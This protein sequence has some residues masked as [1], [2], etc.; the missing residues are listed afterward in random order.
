MGISAA[1]TRENFLIFDIHGAYGELQE[2]LDKAKFDPSTTRLLVGGDLI[3]RGDDSRSV[4]KLLR[5][6]NAECIKGNHEQKTL[7]YYKAELNRKATGAKNTIH[8]S[9]HKI[10]VLKS[11]DETDLI[12]LDALPLKIN[13]ANEWWMIHAG[14]ESAIPFTLQ[15]E[16][17]LLRCRYLDRK[18]RVVKTRDQLPNTEHWSSMWDQPYSIIA[19][20]QVVEKPTIV[21]N[22]NNTVILAD[23]GCCFGGSLTGY[24]FERQQFISVRAKKPY[25]K[26]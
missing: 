20:H 17:T 9:Q 23:T 6:L 16:D 22:K 12:W 4:V 18:G 10:D 19:G 24:F 14:V 1:K 8:I 21:K 5:S 11:L 26:R 25:W 15:S 2:L 3:N 7:D 13:I